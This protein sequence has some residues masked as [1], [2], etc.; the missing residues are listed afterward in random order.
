VLIVGVMFLAL[1]VMSSA[2]ATTDLVRMAILYFE[3]P[4]A[5]IIGW[6]LLRRSERRSAVLIG[7]EAHE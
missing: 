4:L 6:L 5:L 7:T 2:P 3:I 1:I